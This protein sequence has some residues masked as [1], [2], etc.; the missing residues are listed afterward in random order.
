MP[1]ILALDQGTTSSR[2]IVFD[3][4]GTVHGFAQQE[5]PQHYPQPGWV[6]H[7]PRDLWR[8]QLETARNALTNARI[9]AHDIAALG[10]TNQRETTIVWDRSTGAPLY[11]AIVWQ[12]RRTA[13]LC[14][15][16]KAG[17]NEARVTEITGLLLDPY[18]SG[19]KLAWLLA[20]V[21]NVRE[22]A[23]R[24]EVAFG[25]VDS[26]LTYNLTCG[27]RHVTDYT[28]ASR[29]LLFDLE[30]L[31]WSDEMLA[32]LDIPRSM[33]P[34]VLPS[35]AR[36]GTC[37]PEH[38][39]AAIP[40]GGI[41]GDQH[42]ALVGQAGFARGSAKNT[43]GTGS[44]L[45]LNTADTI[46]R[47]RHGLLSTVAYAFENGKAAYALEGSIFVTGAAVGWLRDG[48]GIIS[49]SAEVE[50]LARRVDDN[51]GVYFV[52]AFVGLG[53]PHWD[54]YA[55]GAIVGLTRGSTREHI[56]R[57]A[58]E[59]MAYQTVDIVR[60]ME[61]DAELTLGE[62]R[63]DGGAATNDFTMQFVADMLG[64]DVVR[65][66]VTETT[67]LGAAYLA[68][69]SAGVWDDT[70]AIARQWHEQRRFVCT[71]DPTQRTRLLRAW[72]RAVSR[73]GRWEERDVDLH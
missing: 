9:A 52:P 28:N 63:V 39:G 3:Q 64:V 60:A 42:A 49:Q 23:Q 24:G 54:P 7:D 37:A 47:S 56:A 31:T 72:H 66:Q 71:A 67:A 40:I 15:A 8:S 41:A 38:L 6:E 16:L 32:L 18:F 11:P 5:F 1:Y 68:G 12:D 44:F 30:R 26:W 53:A 59:A 14:E 61:A 58:L 73:A 2:S 19:T 36:F 17:G 45:L 51:G 62:L 20:N 27:A 4:T 50:Q 46:V 48:L 21:P 25:T 65:P 43:Y 70:D 34:Q 22:R 69:L 35:V 55:R 10:I 57:A 29:T 33:L 13:P